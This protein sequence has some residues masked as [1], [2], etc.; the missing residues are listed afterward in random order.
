[1]NPTNDVGGFTDLRRWG[2]A[3]LPTAVSRPNM[4]NR[5][6]FASAIRGAS[7]PAAHKAG[8]ETIHRLRRWDSGSSGSLR[9]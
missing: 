9:L 7:H 1:M 2:F 4:N 6:D 3:A 8:Y 5:T